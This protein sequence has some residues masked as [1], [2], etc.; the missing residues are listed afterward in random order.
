MFGDSRPNIKLVTIRQGATVPRYATSG[1][2]GVD[3]YACLPEPVRLHAG[4]RQIIPTGIAVHIND[5][6]LAGFLLPR[7][8]LGHKQGLVLGNLVG[9][10]DSDYQGE[11][12]ISAWNS[13]VE[14]VVT[15]KPGMKIA[16]LVIMPVVQATYT[17]VDMFDQQTERGDGGFGSSGN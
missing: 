5:R 1:S 2:A 16:Q 3:L 12:L 9:L 14:G 8:G 4:C 10:I 13:K 17:I 6:E 15:I 7:S 11:L